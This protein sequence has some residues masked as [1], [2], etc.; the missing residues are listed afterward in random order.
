MPGSGRADRTLALAPPESWDEESKGGHPVDV[1]AGLAGK[2]D[3]CQLFQGR[4]FEESAGSPARVLHPSPGNMGNAVFG[5]PHGDP[6]DLLGG[7]INQQEGPFK[8]VHFLESGIQRVPEQTCGLLQLTGLGLS[9]SYAGIHI[10]TTWTSWEPNWLG[11]GP[12]ILPKR[13]CKSS[14][15]AGPASRSLEDM[16]PGTGKDRRKTAGEF[17]GRE[18]C[19]LMPGMVYTVP[20]SG[21][22][23]PPS[24]NRSGEDNL[25]FT[26][27]NLPGKL[28]R[29][30]VRDTYRLDTGRLLMVATDRISAFDV[31][32]PTGI[33]KKGLVLN[34]MSAFWFDQ[35]N[36]IVGNHLIALAD[37]PEAAPM[38]RGEFI[39]CRPA[40]AKWPSRPWL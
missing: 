18:R 25:V 20:R 26:E 39:A 7:W 35:T 15:A 32:L 16:K 9:E 10:R 31:V 13:R 8:S 5:F 38:I 2:G 23:P 28:N 19:H 27:T 4:G 17:Y 36:H 3:G 22:D 21:G 24:S 12:I 11:I 29:G 6:A 37:S 34:R 1:P 30:K 40:P 14:E 33:P